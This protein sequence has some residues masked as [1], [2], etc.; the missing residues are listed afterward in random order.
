MMLLGMIGSV[1]LVVALVG[2]AAFVMLDVLDARASDLPRA[3][4]R[5][6]RRT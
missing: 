6:G 4:A 5:R 1:A 2:G 3:I